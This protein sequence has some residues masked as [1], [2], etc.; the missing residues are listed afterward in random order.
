MRRRG[1]ETGEGQ[2][3]REERGRP[4]TSEEAVR[5]A[6]GPPL[7]QRKLIYVGKPC[8]EAS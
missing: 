5:F 6:G 2:I 3:W 8:E 4:K 7:A 1:G